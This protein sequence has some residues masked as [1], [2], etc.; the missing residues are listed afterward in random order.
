MAR[1]AAQ[2]QAEREPRVTAPNLDQLAERLSIAFTRRTAAD[3]FT[4]LLKPALQLLARG[5]PVTPDEI[6]VAAGRTPAAVL[7]ALRQQP[8]VEWD[9]AGRVVGLGLTLRPTPHRFEVDGRTLFTWCALDTLMFPALLG[10]RA[11]VT[12]PCPITGVQV[13]AA[14]AAEHAEQVEPADA[15]VSLVVPE[16]IED[17]RRAFCH[18]VHFLSS[19]EAA[20]HWRAEHPDGLTLPVADAFQLGQMLIRLR[21][22]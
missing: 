13:R 2:G 11:Q 4:P 18:Q 8:S 16:V 6:A 5:S 17:L 7:A 22:L 9:E 19:P 21:A 3:A 12:S 14:V 1:R 10:T 20:A 15:L